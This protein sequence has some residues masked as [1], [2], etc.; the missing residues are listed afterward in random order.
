MPKPY[1]F[2][3]YVSPDYDSDDLWDDDLWD[4]DE[5]DLSLPTTPAAPEDFFRWIFD[6]GERFAAFHSSEGYHVDLLARFGVAGWGKEFLHGVFEL[7][8]RRVELHAYSGV[9]SPSVDREALQ[10][11]ISAFLLG[12]GPVTDS[13]YSRHL[14]S[15][16]WADGRLELERDGERVAHAELERRLQTRVD[17]DVGPVV[18]GHVWQSGQR[19]HAAHTPAPDVDA[20]RAALGSAL[21]GATIEFEEVDAQR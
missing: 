13:R 9:D 8:D 7:D 4:D 5:V 20:L 18:H 14:R 2:H 10:A 15:F 3:D 12:R 16:V 1:E 6:G 19:R 21:P 11:H 17:Q